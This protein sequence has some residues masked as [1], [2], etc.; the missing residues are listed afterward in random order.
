MY[1]IAMWFKKTIVAGQK[2]PLMTD[3]CRKQL[4]LNCKNVKTDNLQFENL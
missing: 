1:Y 3:V 4:I 2:Q